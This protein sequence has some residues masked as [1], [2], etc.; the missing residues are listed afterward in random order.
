[1]AIIDLG[2]VKFNLIGDWDAS[3]TYVKDDVVTHANGMWICTNPVIGDGTDSYAP[4]FLAKGYKGLTTVEPTQQESVDVDS[5]DSI[6]DEGVQY[7]SRNVKDTFDVYVAD[8]GSGLQNVYW[9]DG[10]KHKSITLTSGYTYR[11][12]QN[13]SSNYTHPIVFSSTQG[14]THNSGTNDITSNVRY[15][16]NGEEVPYPIYQGTFGNQSLYDEKQFRSVEIDVD[17]T[18]STF[19]MYC[20]NH[21]GMYIGTITAAVGW[22][23]HKYWDNISHSINFRGEWDSTT[24]YYYNDLVTYKGSLKKA[25]KDTIGD[26]APDQGVAV[27]ATSTLVDANADKRSWKNSWQ[28]VLGGQGDLPKGAIVWGP[29][30]GPMGWPYKHTNLS[31]TNNYRTKFAITKDGSIYSASPGT[32]GGGS[33]NISQ[34]TYMQDVIFQGNAH[35]ETDTWN[36][37]TGYQR[38]EFKRN[39]RHHSDTRP[40]MIQIEYGYGWGY[41]LDEGGNVWH[42][43]YG[44]QGQDA[45]NYNNQGQTHWIQ[46]PEDKKVIKIAADSQQEDN[47]HTCLALCE[48]GTVV[49]WGYNTYG[50]CAR[51]YAGQNPSTVFN[52]PKSYFDGLRVIDIAAT[53]N[54]DSTMFAR[55]E[56]D[57]IWCWGRGNS[58]VHGQNNTNHYYLPVKIPGWDPVANAGIKVFVVAG[59]NTNTCAYILDGN[60][61]IWHSGYNGYGQAM[62]TDTTNHQAGWV[63]SL[64]VPNGDIV[65]IWPIHWN[66]YHTTFARRSD[67]T[68]WVAGYGSGGYYGTGTGSNSNISPPSQADKI[69]NL[70]QVQ[71]MS[72]YSNT[73]MAMWLTDEG[74]FFTQ[75]Y[76][77]YNTNPNPIAGS[78]W[79]GEDGTYK[80]YHTFRPA[81]ERVKFFW[82]NGIYQSTNYFGPYPY[83][84]TDRGSLYHWGYSGYSTNGSNFLCGNHQWAYNGNPGGTMIQGGNPR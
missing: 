15:Y 17:N 57:Q 7:G 68:T 72:T 71:I 16:L 66:S 32:N 82:I 37:Q 38:K 50:Q 70:R 31:C 74:E 22:A 18:N 11:F 40:G 10:Q 26:T 6:H 24:Q 56:D 43:G 35:K 33:L 55:T 64:A 51:G 8:D 25:L 62:G 58:G 47:T 30:M 34:P 46:M 29:D 65:D 53:G 60:G 61:Y 27:M 44:G 54:N 79:N 41:S 13:D 19:Y 78:P 67:G 12:Q 80:P 21:S 39:D 36:M 5:W 75:G 45:G 9:I 76:D 4:G 1:M 77:N 49:T 14:G 28:D 69:N 3:T 81:G 20:P 59:Y 42:W 63:K 2:K 84:I 73:H 83:M 52:L 23:G 48:D